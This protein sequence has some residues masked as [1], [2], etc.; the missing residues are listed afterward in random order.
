VLRDTVGGEQGK[1]AIKGK[2]VMNSDYVQGF[3]HKCAE[4]NV[5]PDELMKSAGPAAKALG[6]GSGV[7]ALTGG[8]Y[9]VGRHQQGE[10]DKEKY[11]II[12][13]KLL[14]RRQKM[15]ESNLVQRLLTAPAKE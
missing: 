3:Q 13:S 6:I 5:S 7:A 14:R 12:I 2:Y 8:G 10:A 1:Y 15:T 4:L 11:G 9:A